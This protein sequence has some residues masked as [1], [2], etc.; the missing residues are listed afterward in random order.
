MSQSS[1]RALL[2]TAGVGIG[3]FAI[4]THQAKA[5][6][7]SY[8][9]GN[10][11]PAN[12]PLN[13]RSNE[14]AAKIAEDSGGRLELRVF[15]NNQ[16]GADTDMLAQLRS[17][18]LEMFAI[19]GI[20]VL[21]AL[22]KVTSLY[23]VAFAF[24][25]YDVMWSALDGDLGAYL[26]QQIEKLNLYAL[27]KVWDNGFRQVTSGT[28]PIRTPDDLKG[29]KIRVPVSRLWTSTFQSLGASPVSV[30]FAE[31]YTALK[32]KIADG[33]ENPLA[34]IYFAKFY[35]VQKYCAMTN[36]MWDGLFNAMNGRA[37]RALP[38]NLQAVLADNM[39]MAVIKGRADLVELNKTVRSKL[40]ENGMVFN[41]TDRSEFQG[42]LSKNGYYKQWQETFGPEAWA[43]LEKYSGPLV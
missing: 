35:E 4:L 42:T 5:A 41:D 9:F 15:P 7:F 8:K 6:E 17:G 33:Q 43:L 22:N 25:D 32:T 36:H 38:P 29:F 13:I 1:R 16:L 28:K 39:N 14:A 10:N 23:G 34:L 31:A 27:E 3:T 21:S 24:P 18:A 20:N 37:W 19:S 12:H 26:R 40:E 11:Q 2:Q 30:N